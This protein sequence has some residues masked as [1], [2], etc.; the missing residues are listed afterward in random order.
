[1]GK[2]NS[3]KTQ[4]EKGYSLLELLVILGIIGILLSLLFV[5]FSYVQEKQNIKQALI[6]MAVLQTGIIAYEA[7]FGN[8]PNCPEKICTPGSVFFYRCWA[9]IMPR[10]T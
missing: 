3:L 8:Y 1:M 9:F 2:E 4:K 6:E 7:E 5:G 10:E